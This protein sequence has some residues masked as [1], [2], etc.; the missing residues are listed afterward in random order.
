MFDAI[1]RWVVNSNKGDIEEILKCAGIPV[2][3]M[4]VELSK[5]PEDS[6]P[7]Y[8]DVVIT[9]QRKKAD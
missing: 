8:I 4:I 3:L 2:Q 6:K 5:H 1:N 7:T 9:C